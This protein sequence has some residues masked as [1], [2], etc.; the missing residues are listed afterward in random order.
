MAAD[1][2][3]RAQAMED[4]R[5]QGEEREAL[6]PPLPQARGQAGGIWPEYLAHQQGLAYQQPA[7]PLAQGAGQ[8]RVEVPQGLPPRA[9]PIWRQWADQVNFG[10]FLGLEPAI[11]DQH[12]LFPEAQQ[13]PL[14]QQPLPARNRLLRRTDAFPRFEG[15]D[16]EDVFVF[17]QKMQGMLRTTD[18]SAPERATAVRMA[19]HGAAALTLYYQ[20]MDATDRDLYQ[21][22][23]R[24]WG[25]CKPEDIRR[26]I[27]QCRQLDGESVE[28]YIQRLEFNFGLAGR[29]NIIIQ[30]GEALAY[31][32]KGLTPALWTF[33]LMQPQDG[34]GELVPKLVEYDRAC[35]EA[36]EEVE[37]AKKWAETLL[38]KKGKPQVNVVASGSGAYSQSQLD[39]A[40]ERARQE[41]RGHPQPALTAT[42]VAKPLNRGLYTGAKDFSWADCHVCKEKGHIRYYCPTL[43]EEERATLRRTLE[44]NNPR[45][46]TS[47]RSCVSS[48]RR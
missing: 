19:V 32:K 29:A 33:A 42:I 4:Q 8:G 31:L 7:I 25:R 17:V 23:L 36:E 47:N 22:L 48:P 18:Y 1:R 41:E 14:P 43:S 2:M 24:E 35:R 15:K 16:G 30:P 26:R 46:G 11:G 27:E 34:W 20:P 9:M 28:L 5:Q 37:I 39:E 13:E 12:D 10:M 21:S 3:R 45:K 6:Y 38:G 44:K 40:V